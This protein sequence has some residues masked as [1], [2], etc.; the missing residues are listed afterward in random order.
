MI[1]VLLVDDHPSVM[2]GTK[3]LLEQEGDIS[4]RLAG[5]AAAATELAG[6]QRFDVMLVDLQMPDING[7]ELSK[8]ILGIRPE[9]TIL[10]YTGFDFGNHFNLMVESGLAGFLPKTVNREQLVTAVRC[11]ARGEAVLPLE[12]LKQ[13]RRPGAPKQEQGPDHA[14]SAVTERDRQILAEIARGKSNKEIAQS[15]LIS[16]RSLEYALTDL[17]Q[18]LKVKSRVEAVMK[19]GQLG[20]VEDAGSADLLHSHSPADRHSG[21]DAI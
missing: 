21:L 4:V 15:L 19:A 12:L 17:F 9:A 10:I 18:K 20:I 14:S 2:E 13:L 1:E 7:L 5:T 3:L 6:R 8:R 11:A 16:Q